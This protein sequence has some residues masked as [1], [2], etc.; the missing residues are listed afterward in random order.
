MNWSK[1]DLF[2]NQWTIISPFGIEVFFYT[3]RIWKGG[4][5]NK[6]GESVKSLPIKILFLGLTGPA[7]HEPS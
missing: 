2:S 3:Y 1:I 5:G 7:H 6:K 4:N